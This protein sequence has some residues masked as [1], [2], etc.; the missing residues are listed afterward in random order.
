LFLTRWHPPLK[1]IRFQMIA[2]IQRIHRK[3]DEFAQRFCP[4]FRHFGV[5]Y[6]KYRYQ[7]IVL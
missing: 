1:K 7:P 3:L 2:N 6:N 4:I 5:Q